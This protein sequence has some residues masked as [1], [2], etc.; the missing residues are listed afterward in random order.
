MKKNFLLALMAVPVM[1]LVSF[2]SCGKKGQTSTEGIA[3]EYK[4]LY[5]DYTCDLLSDSIFNPMLFSEETLSDGDEVAS[6]CADMDGQYAGIGSSDEPVQ[7][8]TDVYNAFIML[9]NLESDYETAERFD[10]DTEK[11]SVFAEMAQE[12]EQLDLSILQD[13]TIRGLMEAAKTR[14]I[15][16]MKDQSDEN[17]EASTEAFTAFYEYIHTHFDALMKECE[18]DYV[19]YVDRVAWF[20]I[21]EATEKR[22]QSDTLYQ[23]ELLHMID[24]AESAEERHVYV[25]EFAHSSNDHAY[26]YPGAAVEDR[27]IAYFGEYSPYLLEIWQTWRATIS[28]YYGHSSWSY[29]PN[30]MY[31]RQRAKTANIILRHIEENKDDRYAQALLVTLGGC[32][33]ISRFGSIFGNAS[34]IE[35]MN[36]FPE[37]NESE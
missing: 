30:Q 3:Y 33:N 23:R 22:G 16:F 11:G 8:L 4:S 14:I 19:N 24:N 26:F 20:D 10:E 7:Y 29:I 13:D 35:Q 9:H 6:L 1:C 25:L 5:H 36:L 21:Y 32:E 37:W 2:V 15:T 31:N 12:M 18:D 17:Q 28:T 27:E 34:I